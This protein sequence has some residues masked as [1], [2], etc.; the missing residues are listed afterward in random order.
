MTNT[1]MVPLPQSPEKNTDWI[2]VFVIPT[3]PPKVF[4]E[5]IKVA[6]IRARGDIER[7]KNMVTRG[8]G[9]GRPAVMAALLQFLL[10]G[11]APAQGWLCTLTSRQLCSPIDDG[12]RLTSRQRFG[13]KASHCLSP[14]PPGQVRGDSCQASTKGNFICSVILSISTVSQAGASGA[15]G[16]CSIKEKLRRPQTWYRPQPGMGDPLQ[17]GGSQTALCP[18]VTRGAC[19]GDLNLLALG[20][21]LLDLGPAGTQSLPGFHNWPKPG[22]ASGHTEGMWSSGLWL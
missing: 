2:S 22:R 14:F 12:S 8:A 9:K 13:G 18:R 20:A 16:A 5:S 19:Y 15:Q 17:N 7:E 4:G 10:G 6:Q 1:P 3:E 21:C 11:G